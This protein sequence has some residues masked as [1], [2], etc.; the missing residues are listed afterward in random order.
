MLYG[1]IRILAIN[2]LVFSS[3]VGCAQ[4]SM[5]SFSEPILHSPLGE[6][7]ACETSAVVPFTLLGSAGPVRMTPSKTFCLSETGPSVF[8]HAVPLA[9]LRLADGRRI[10]FVREPTNSFLGIYLQDIESNWQKIQLDYTKRS[11]LH[12]EHAF[13]HDDRAFFLAYNVELSIPSGRRLQSL[14]EGLD[15]YEIQFSG[16]EVRTEQVP[17]ASWSAG[18]E[19]AVFHVNL[20]HRTLICAALDCNEMQIA[21]GTVK[22]TPIHM[23]LPQ[24]S[25]HRIV[26]FIGSGD[27]AY[28]LIQREY[29]DRLHGWPTPDAQ[30]FHLCTVEISLECTPLNTNGTPWNLTIKNN[31]ASYQI[32]R[33]AEDYADLLAF[34]LHRLRQS[35]V[36]N[37]MENNIEGRIAWSA[38]YY[39]NGIATLAG[40]ESGLGEHF[41]K[42]SENARLRL[43]GELS[44]WGDA[45]ERRYP[46]FQAK[47]YSIDR[48]PLLSVLHLGRIVR[49][50]ARSSDLSD[51]KPK[52]ATNT[53]L[54]SIMHPGAD[55]LEYVSRPS[56]GRTELRIHQY[57]AFWA[58]GTNAPWNY[59]S[60][61]IDGLA[62]LDDRNL[63]LTYKDAV[64]EMLAQFIADE[65]LLSL[66][67]DWNYASGDTFNG[68]DLDKS[69]SSNTPS[70]VGD[71]TNTQ[72]AH[73]SYRTMDV[74]A[75]LSADRIG[76][77]PL[78]PDLKK[79][80][81][82]LID[83]GRV[84]PFAMEEAKKHG[85]RLRLTRNAAQLFARTVHPYDL[86]SQVWVIPILVEEE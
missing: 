68:W 60:G 84:W 66:P 80:L 4:T 22:L 82:S 45:L 71:R 31:E 15:L 38:V 69:V 63:N 59:Q 65:R 72:T 78:S 77:S 85:H 44:F 42:L 37:F 6:A 47:R 56:S 23:A 10:I 16:D 29:D 27:R 41:V 7:S 9:S 20:D 26:E 83:R 25:A 5:Q 21:N 1:T 58:D 19:S 3:S 39:L 86:Q 50:I 32:A 51:V 76:L 67:D 30:V 54:V 8:G 18:L 35:G 48:E 11:K 53:R 17:E 52:Q 28:M 81:F 73:I 74:M 46:G 34:D 13:L 43:K 64:R 57:A 40:D 14:S 24:G 70:W 12:F 2:L 33:N 75:L 62:A 49:V 55:T 61:W 36:A 79:H